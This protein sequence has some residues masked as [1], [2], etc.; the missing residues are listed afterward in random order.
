LVG[1]TDAAKAAGR[2][3]RVIL[4]RERDGSL[5]VLLAGPPPPELAPEAAALSARLSQAFVQQLGGRLEVEEGDPTV[6]RVV[7]PPTGPN[8]A[9]AGS[10]RALG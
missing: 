7:L 6:A 1:F 8:G 9:G 3:A 2:P 5:L 10:D 4:R